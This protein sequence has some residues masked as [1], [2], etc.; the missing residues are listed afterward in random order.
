[1]SSPANVTTGSPTRSVPRNKSFIAGTSGP[2]ATTPPERRRRRTTNPMTTTP[3]AIT[4]TRS[5]QNTTSINRTSVLFA[6][7][8]TDRPRPIPRYRGAPRDP[9]DRWATPQAMMGEALGLARI[10]QGGSPAPRRLVVARRWLR[11]PPRTQSRPSRCDRGADLDVGRERAEVGCGGPHAA[12]LSLTPTS[13]GAVNGGSSRHRTTT[14]VSIAGGVWYRTS[15][16]T[17]D[18]AGGRVVDVP[19]LAHWRLGLRCPILA[20]SNVRRPRPARHPPGAG[21]PARGSRA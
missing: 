9:P 3:M 18:L 10:V 2:T 5:S 7:S 14:P 11:L 1:M 13:D 17:L 16:S 15:V 8:S 4:A 6:E 19:S 12:P 21:L 20:S